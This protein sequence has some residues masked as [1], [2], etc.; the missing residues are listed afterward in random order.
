MDRQTVSGWYTPEDCARVNQVWNWVNGEGDNWER[1]RVPLRYWSAWG[2][3]FWPA[4][5]TARMVS[6]EWTRG[7]ERYGG[8]VRSRW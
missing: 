5:A 8:L 1:S 2:V 3:D 7:S 4:G 6:S